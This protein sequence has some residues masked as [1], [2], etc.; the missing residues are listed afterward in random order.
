M[1]HYISAE[2]KAANAAPD[3]RTRDLVIITLPDPVDPVTLH[4]AT[5]NVTVD[6]QPYLGRIKSLPVIVYSSGGNPNGGEFVIENASNEFGPTFLN[7]DRQLDGSHVQI[8]RAFLLDTGVWQK[9][10]PSNGKVYEIASGTMSTQP[11]SDL[12]VKCTFVSEWSDSNVTIGGSRIPQHC[13]HT[14]NK[15]GNHPLGGGCGW[16]PSMGGNPLFCNKIQDHAQ[17]CTGHGNTRHS[18]V[19]G[20]TPSAV[21]T[22]P[23]PVVINGGYGDGSIPRRPL[24]LDPDFRTPFLL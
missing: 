10:D 12:E 13:G 15:N 21:S 8:I 11:I 3:T 14:F 7:S 22:Q 20:L 23:G 1:G 24:E 18:G 5:A 9:Q 6:G 19:P 16:Q 2:A 4:L 17:G